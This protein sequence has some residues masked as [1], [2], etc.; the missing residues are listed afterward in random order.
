VLGYVDQT[1]QSPLETWYSANQE[2]I[3]LQGDRLVGTAG[4]D[5]NWVNVLYDRISFETN[6]SNVGL[7]EKGAVPSIA[8]I[9]TNSSLVQVSPSAP[10]IPLLSYR[11]I[12]NVMPGY[13]AQ[14]QEL[15]FLER[16]SGPPGE[17][18][19]QDRENLSSP[20]IYWLQERVVPKFNNSENPGLVSLP[21]FYAV[22]VSKS[23]A[24]VVYGRQCLAVDYCLSW[25]VWPRIERSKL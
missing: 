16:L 19:S 5:V 25:Q 12:R 2:L 10:T 9:V 15:V 14:I 20:S 8:Q 4:L 22:D 7:G 18:S 17:I 6:R 3:Q 1:N 13:R 23:P 11:R 24:Q 21:A